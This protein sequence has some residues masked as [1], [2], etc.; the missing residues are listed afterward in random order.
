MKNNRLFKFNSG[1]SLIEVLVGM[2]IGMLASLIV[3]RTFSASEAFRRNLV[4]SNEVT[5]GIAA[6]TQNLTLALEYAGGGMYQGKN[7]WGCRLLAS[8]AGTPLLPLPSALPSPFSSVPLDVRMLPVGAMDGGSGSDVLFASA[9]YSASGNQQVDIDVVNNSQILATNTNGMNLGS[10]RGDLLLIAP[11]EIADAVGDCQIVQTRNNAPPV[12]FDSSLGMNVAA[13][14]AQSVPA[15]NYN[16]ID[17]DV[18]SYGALISTSNSPAAFHLGKTD[19]PMLSVFGVDDNNQLVEQD[20]LQRKGII[21]IPLEEGIV[22]FKI[23][24]GVDDGAGGSVANDGHIDEWVSPGDNGWR[25]SELITGLPDAEQRIIQIRAI[26]VGLVKRGSNVIT[27]RIPKTSYKIF[28]DLGSRA[29]TYS[30]PSD[31]INYE[32]EIADWVI[33][34]KNRR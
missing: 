26:R 11:Q 25:Y 8:R 24:Y 32:Y 2:V 28:A 17:L 19:Q 27:G 33:P 3:M 13:S 31:L 34:L 6:V 22:F 15:T 18:P 7:I 10:L 9:G 14:A 21:P 1:L 20:L 5:Q 4:S 23:R 12:V 16:V 30:P 29:A